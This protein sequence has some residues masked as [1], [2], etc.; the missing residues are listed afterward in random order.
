MKIKFY[1]YVVIAF[2]IVAAVSVPLNASASVIGAAGK[3]VFPKSN[4]PNPGA[5][6]AGNKSP[7]LAA[8][9]IHAMVVDY[10]NYSTSRSLVA[11]WEQ[12]MKTAGINMVVLNAGRTEWTY[13]KWA[14]HSSSWSS[15]VNSSGVDFLADDSTRYS[16]WAQVNASIDGLS[17]NYIKANPSKAAVDA[18]G[19]ASTDL[20][21]TAELVNGT[22]GQTL[23]SMVGYIAAN[24]PKVASITITGISYHVDG[25]GADDLA[26]YKAAT[27]KTDWPRNSDGSINIDDSSIGN[28]RSAA[29]GQFLGKAAALAH[30]YGK[31]LFMEVGVSVNNLP[32]A[33]NNY[34]TN[35]AVM[36]QNVDKIVVQDYFGA[37]GYSPKYSSNIAQYLAK[38]GAGR[39]ILD[40][41]LWGA[42]GTTVSATDLKYAITT[43]TSG[44]I[45][46]IMVEPESL[47]LSTQWSVLDSLWGAAP[48]PTATSTPGPAATTVPSK[49]STPKATATK[50]TA[51]TA[52]KTSAP[53]ATNTPKA[54]VTN[55]AMPTATNT[56][57]PTATNMPQ[58]TATKTPVPSSTGMH[59][60]SVEYANYATSRSEV[61][62]WVAELKAAGINEVAISAGRPE[63]TYFKWAGHTAYQ[64]NDVTSTG[65]DFLAED[66]ATFSQFAKV[67]AVVDVFGPNYILANPSAAAI[68]ASGQPDPNLISTAELVNG[69]YGQRLLDM[70]QYISANY[71]YVDSIDITELSYRVDGYGAS[72]LALFKAA[73]GKS[74]WPR[75]SDGTI[76]IDDASIG[77]WRSAVIGQWLGRATALAHAYGKKLYMDVSVSWNNL[78]LMTNNMG[79]NYNVMLQNVDEIIAWDYYSLEG[80]APSVSQSVGQYLATFGTNR[81]VLSIGLWGPNSTTVSP[82]DLQAGVLASQVGGMPNVWICP[83]SMMTAAHWQVLDSLWGPK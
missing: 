32:L 72:D 66:S 31:Q 15:D 63:W 46:D 23:L 3:S 44:G 68:N 73:T 78:G 20:V 65:I 58:P 75:N 55:T 37:N 61:P 39:S 8:S 1:R 74:D 11:T 24:Y 53:S 62:T 2:L 59:T 33:T 83:G 80:Y 64:S 13:F 56:S 5:F 47:A 38:I 7:L 35:Y 45:A 28:W 43:G 67:S 16:Q 79:T 30:Q 29:L 81:A 70:V 12:N 25:Y 19:H 52:T 26:L 77:N 14:G 4:N 36:L 40:V 76:N 48:V 42:S 54:T 22:Y 41:G 50:T 17:P 60:M 34:G 57:K 9:A 21:S 71:P 51:P 49:T 18:S 10:P 6:V 69:A 82:A 27:G